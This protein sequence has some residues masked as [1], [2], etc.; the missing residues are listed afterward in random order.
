MSALGHADR[1]SKQRPETATRHVSQHEATDRLYW[2]LVQ[3]DPNRS[4]S[5]SE[6]ER[7][8][9]SYAPHDELPWRL[10]EGLALERIIA[11]VRH[12]GVSAA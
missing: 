6:V 11:G 5:W 12:R 8:A 7:R 1:M 2:L 9:V 4:V 3:R 10:E